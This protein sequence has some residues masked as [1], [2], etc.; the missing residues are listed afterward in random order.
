MTIG[1]KVFCFLGSRYL[2]IWIF[3][4]LLYHLIYRSPSQ[5][6]MMGLNINVWWIRAFCK[7]KVSWT[8]AIRIW[9]RFDDFI[10]PNWLTSPPFRTSV[11]TNLVVLNDFFN[12]RSE[13]CYW[14]CHE[15]DLQSVLV[16]RN[17]FIRIPSIFHSWCLITT[18][19]ATSN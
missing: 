3:L 18:G 5:W 15:F 14:E 16:P 8:N 6:L 12:D 10:F 19:Q 4:F 13:N 1:T 7:S 9:I 2:F 17:V 11:R